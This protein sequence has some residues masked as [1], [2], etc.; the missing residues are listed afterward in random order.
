VFVDVISVS[1]VLYTNCYHNGLKKAIK[2][3]PKKLE[4]M[5]TKEEKVKN[6]TV[7]KKRQKQTTLDQVLV[8]KRL[9]P[10][11]LEVH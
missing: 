4:K 6:R 10:S 7:L 5:L 1:A 3:A 9:R 8:P 11:D 2:M